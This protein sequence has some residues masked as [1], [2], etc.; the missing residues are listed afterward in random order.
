MKR[1][2]DLIEGMKVD[3]RH[4]LLFWRLFFGVIAGAMLSL[5]YSDSP[6]LDQLELGMLNWRYK[7]ADKIAA[8]RIFPSNAADKASQLIDIIAFDDESQF[9]LG[10]ARFN[11]PLAQARLAE[12]IDKIE[13]AGPALVVVDLDLRG[14]ANQA[15]LESMRSHRNVVVSLFGSLEGSTELPSAEF[16]RYALGYGYR[17][18]SKEDGGMVVRLPDQVPEPHVGEPTGTEQVPSLTRAVLTSFFIRSGVDYVSSLTPA[19]PDQYSYI[20]YKRVH[21][22]S[23]SMVSVLEPDFDAARF[24]DK[25]VLIGSTLTQRTKDPNRVKTPFRAASPELEVQAD[26]LGT[27]INNDVVWSFP[28][29]YA[30]QFLLIV[31]AMVG[32]LASALPMGRRALAMLLSGVLLVVLAQFTFQYF[33]LLLPVVAPMVMI[34]TDFILGT[35][36]FLD[37]GLRQRNRELAAAREMMQVR[38]EEERKRIANDLHDETLP[39]LSSIARMVDDMTSEYGDSPAPRQMRQKLDDTIQEMRRVINDLHPS[40]LETMG[41]VPALENL[42]HILEREVR[43]S[44][45]FVADTEIRESD[46]PTFAKLQLYRIVQEILNN[47][48]KHSGADTVEVKVKRSG[49]DLQISVVDNGKG[50]DPRAI[51]PDSHGLLNIRHRANLIGAFVEW[52]QP[53][54]YLNGTEFNLSMPIGVRDG[55]ELQKGLERKV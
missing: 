40:V 53:S 3:G 5:V 35:V 51:R 17:E 39:A 8:T 11:D 9:D 21:Y 33:H 4:S 36:I 49:D 50:I 37:T 30:K 26:A 25:I 32:A 42:V 34:V 54:N 22:P 6:L 14:S 19:K 28:H 43:I 16:L 55:A 1:L 18:L 31:G 44:G 41:F 23:F 45:N 12:L 24:K 47:V 27:V 2:S 46:V 13:Q 20:N 48:R 10:F 7:I 29:G 38:A 52:R 15:L